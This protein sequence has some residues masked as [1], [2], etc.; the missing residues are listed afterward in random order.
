MSIISKRY[1]SVNI[2]IIDYGMGNLQS[3]KNSL[4]RFGAYADITNDLFRESDF[5]DLISGYFNDD[6]L[7]FYMY[8]DIV[9]IKSKNI[10]SVYLSH[11]HLWSGIAHY[12]LAKKF[13]FTGRKEGALSGN[14]INYDNIDEKLCEIHCWFKF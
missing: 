10:R 1:E 9:R 2:V 14:I 11:F 8:P 7:F 4:F 3:V 12:E 6:E 5:D 13:G